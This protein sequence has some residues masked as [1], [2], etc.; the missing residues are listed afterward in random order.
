MHTGRS[1]RSLRSDELF[2]VGYHLMLESA[3]QTQ[4]EYDA[5]EKVRKYLKNIEVEAETGM[6]A[7]P[8]W[9]MPADMMGG[10]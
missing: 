1:L 3:R 8:D 6:P 2:P 9:A 10:R 4:E 7:L 5:Q